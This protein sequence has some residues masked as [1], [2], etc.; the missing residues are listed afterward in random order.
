MMNNDPRRTHVYSVRTSP[1]SSASLIDEATPSQ[2]TIEGNR[3]CF[4]YF[5]RSHSAKSMVF[6]F[7]KVS[8]QICVADFVLMLLSGLP[9]HHQGLLE[10]ALR[11]LHRAR[12]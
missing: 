2:F 4:W 12:L 3:V 9:E 1:P 11:E 7:D 8:Y 5:S 10:S 6:D